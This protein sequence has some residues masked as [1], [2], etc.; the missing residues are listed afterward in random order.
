MHFRVWSQDYTCEYTDVANLD[1]MEVDVGPIMITDQI[2]FA[3]GGISGLLGFEIENMTISETHSD[4][5]GYGVS[6]NGA[7]DG[8]IDITV[9]GGTAPYTYTWSNGES[10]EDVSNLGAGTYSVTA[11]DV[12]GCSVSVFS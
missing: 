11:T 1:W 9:E 3:T 12:N 6:C 8:S 5:T 7:S 2:S 10:T 4:Y